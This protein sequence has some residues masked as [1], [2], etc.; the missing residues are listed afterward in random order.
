M[1][2]LIFSYLKHEFEL[3]WVDSLVTWK[4]ASP[5]REGCTVQ[6]ASCC[7]TTKLWIRIILC[8]SSLLF[9]LNI[10]LSH[11]TY[12]LCI[13]LLEH[14]KKG[15]TTIKVNLLRI[16]TLII[17][18]KYFFCP[19]HSCVWHLPFWQ[20]KLCLTANNIGSPGPILYSPLFY[21]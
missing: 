9:D 3:F 1:S 4:A 10:I 21:F 15:A 8:K 20:D 6:I 13:L 12:Y 18:W 16:S 14:W 17:D 19:Q 2:L 11:T 5:S 7:A